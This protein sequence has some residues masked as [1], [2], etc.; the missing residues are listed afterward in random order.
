VA[1]GANRLPPFGKYRVKRRIGEGAFGS[2]YEAELAGP[3]GF[4]KA[5]ALKMLRPHLVDGEPAFVQSMI[6]EARIGGLLHHANIV[7]ILEFGQEGSRY[8]LAMEFVDGAT[9]SDIIKLCGM[10]DVL[11]PRFAIIDLALQV[12]RGLHYA[13]TLE[14][15]DGQPLHLVHRDLKPS[16]IIVDRQGT[17]KILDFGIAKAASNLFGAT[18]PGL[19]KGTP[20]YMSPEQLDGMEALTPA[21]DVFSL[22]LV[23]YEV[24]T[25]E[26]LFQADTMP[27]L[28]AKICE[29]D[30][31][32]HLDRAEASFPGCRPI[33]ERALQRDLKDR[34]PDCL[35]LAQDLRELG[36]QH[37]AE[38]EMAEI[39]GRLMPVVDRTQSQMISAG[40]SR[41]RSG[42]WVG[43]GPSPADEA[44]P[45]GEPE[46]LSLAAAEWD[47]FSSVFEMPREPRADGDASTGSPAPPRVSRASAVVLAIA[48]VA[49]L[50]S[51]VALVAAW[52]GWLA[53]PGSEWDG[54]VE[55]PATGAEPSSTAADA[56][57]EAKETG[58][59]ATPASQPTPMPP[60]EVRRETA[61]ES[62][63][64]AVVEPPPIP[65]PA[66]EA[67][68]VEEAAPAG[69]PAPVEEETAAAEAPSPEEEPPG[70]PPVEEGPPLAPG[71]VSLYTQPWSVIHV[72]G[73]E[74]RSGNLLKKHPLEGGI[75]RIRLVCPTRDNAEKTFE[76][77]VDG[78][79]LNLGCWDFG[80]MAPCSNR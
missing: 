32:D 75:H 41:T 55:T 26:V 15:R 33:L 57:P 24:I 63:V 78:A 19:V 60:A 12:C 52:Q 36:H 27:E 17:A 21:S 70:D 68:P 53:P 29:L 45:L 48:L 49:L 79:D 35:A 13:H 6:N 61:P 73:V 9:L 4:S 42:R 23:L 72:D 66:E 28:V 62:T 47:R 40:S 14:D 3:M 22:G 69:E 44:T 2:V 20:R 16:N 67:A 43:G 51:S 5:V 64:E 56:G 54:V 30:L 77:T 50:A 76:F 31:T 34:Y 11:L 38:A 37:P 25:G 71:T 39:I 7:D 65:P 1:G 58:E 74:L 59:P 18:A 8:Y 10:R 80:T 46:T